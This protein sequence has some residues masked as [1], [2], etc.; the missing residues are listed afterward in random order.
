MTSQRL[1]KLLALTS[2][3]ATI[4]AVTIWRQTGE[5]P[6]PWL[7]RFAAA[8]FGCA[9]LVFVID[10]ETRPRIMLQFLAALFATIALFAFAADFSAARGAGSG[11]HAASLLDRLND[12]AP[13]LV[14]SARNGVTRLLGARVWDPVITSIAGLPAFVVFIAV[15]MFCGFSGR[16]RREVQIYIN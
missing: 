16:P 5:A 1:L 6:S 4:A 8:A 15:A 9:F 14:N 12:F 3:V 10:Q 2:L 11:F 7:V 13:S